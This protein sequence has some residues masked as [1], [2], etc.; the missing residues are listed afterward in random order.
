MVEIPCHGS[1]N[2]T[3]ALAICCPTKV[4]ALAQEDCICDSFGPLKCEFA[5]PGCGRYAGYSVLILPPA[6]AE[7]YRAVGLKLV[8]LHCLV[9]TP[10]STLGI[11]RKLHTK[12]AVY[13]VISSL[14]KQPSLPE[15]NLCES[16]R[17]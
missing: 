12:Q 13:R 16:D 4:A 14:A 7:G 15:C 6:S 1:L 9:Q 8:I 11:H 5:Q 10:P 17:R 3:Q 2:L